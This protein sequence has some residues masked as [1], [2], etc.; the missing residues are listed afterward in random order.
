MSSSL[1][2]CWINLSLILLN[3]MI[4]KAGLS[5]CFRSIFNKP[6]NK[7]ECSFLRESMKASDSSLFCLINL[8][9]SIINPY[10]NNK[11]IV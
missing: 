9:T 4:V 6:F 1:P 2:K 3:D 8:A 10:Y 5:L 7:I 11:A